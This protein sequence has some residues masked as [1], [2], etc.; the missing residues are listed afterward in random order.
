VVDMNQDD[1]KT[2]NEMLSKINA[3]KAVNEG[4]G[5]LDGKDFKKQLESNINVLE[6]LEVEY[7]KFMDKVER[8]RLAELKRKQE[9]GQQI[10]KND[11]EFIGKYMAHLSKLKLGERPSEEMLLKFTQMK[12]KAHVISH[13]RNMMLK[14]L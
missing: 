7:Q 3:L 8:N 1:L 13:L 12:R 14:G 10:I 6:K 11:I 5:L 2:K 9:E 4:L